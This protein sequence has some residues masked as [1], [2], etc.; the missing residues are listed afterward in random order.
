MNAIVF[1]YLRT[2]STQCTTEIKTAT[3]KLLKNALTTIGRFCFVNEL[4]ITLDST[5]ILTSSQTF[6]PTFLEC[7][8]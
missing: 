7:K 5:P 6:L 3:E 1:K 4:D 8:H 2:P